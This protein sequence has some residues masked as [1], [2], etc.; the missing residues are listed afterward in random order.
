[1]EANEKVL[2]DYFEEL[3]NKYA[4]S[5]LWVCYSMLKAMLSKKEGVNIEKYSELLKFIKNKQ[6]LSNAKP[7]DKNAGV[8]KVQNVYDFINN[9]PDEKYLAA[10][11]NRIIMKS[12]DKYFY[13]YEEKYIIRII[14]F[15]F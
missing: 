7:R 11:V 3:S 9:A 4:P 15:I 2:V 13:A 1:M 5:T 6:S 12:L 8:L 14:N 10:K